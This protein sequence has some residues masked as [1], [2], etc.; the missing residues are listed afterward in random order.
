MNVQLTCVHRYDYG[1][2]TTK[3]KTHSC[4]LPVVL[5][6]HLDAFGVSYKVCEDIG[7]RD[8]RLL[9]RIKSL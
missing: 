3:S 5:C 8:V 1:Q 4:L 2:H 7:R 6:I 9:S